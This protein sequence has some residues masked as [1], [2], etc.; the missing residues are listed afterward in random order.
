MRVFFFI[1]VIA[2]V[3][4]CSYVSLPL[5]AERYYVVVATF[6][7]KSSAE[8]FAY[9]LKSVFPESSFLFREQRRLYHVYATS[10]TEISRAVTQAN[11]IKSKTGFVDAWI[12]TAFSPEQNLSSGRSLAERQPRYS[13]DHNLSVNSSAYIASVKEAHKPMVRM[14]SEVQEK[15]L[16]KES[17]GIKFIPGIKSLHRL[18]DEIKTSAAYVLSF[19]VEENNHS[20][21]ANISLLSRK[22]GEKIA[23][24]ATDELAAL[25]ANGRG[26]TFFFA[27]DIPGYSMSTVAFNPERLVATTDMKPNT[28]GVWEVRFNVSKLAVDK[29]EL[30]YNLLFSPNTALMNSDFRTQ[31]EALVV[32]LSS[33]AWYKIVINS[34]CHPAPKRE[35][36][37]RGGDNDFFDIKGAI[38]KRGTDKLLTKE[39]AEAFRDYLISRGVDKRKIVVMGWGSMDPMAR[40]SSGDVSMNDR[41]E[42]ELVAR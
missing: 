12:F 30:R 31:V 9:S 19:A 21:P 33:N 15:G 37:V 20:I 13:S 1:K 34:H 18:N 26:E 36:K 6:S 17:G 32:L 11:Q 35:I 22:K 24:F 14:T 41:T 42:I 10:T 16:W 2:L 4:F 39:R 38:E 3:V 25:R 27:C 5:Q 7:Q 23:T 8:D 40:G 28:E 29:L